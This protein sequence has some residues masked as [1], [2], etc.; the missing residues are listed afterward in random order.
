MVG[1]LSL[2]TPTVEFDVPKSN[3]QSGM[4]FVVF[5]VAFKFASK[6]VFDVA[7]DVASAKSSAGE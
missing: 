2:N 6:A 7:H 4:L 5:K 3:P 1:R